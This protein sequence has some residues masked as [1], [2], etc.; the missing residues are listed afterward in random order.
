MSEPTPA[1]GEYLADPADLALKLGVP[2][3]DARLLLALR[4]AGDRFEGAIG[5]PVRLVTDDV[6][7]V[8]GDGTDTLLLRCRPIVGQP[9]VKVDGVAVTDFS[10]GRHSGILR[11]KNRACW[12]DDLDNVEVTYSHGW[13]QVP[14]DIQDAVLEQAE[15]QY[16]TVVAYQSRSAGSESVTY[17][18]LAAV[19]VTQRWT[20]AV[21]RY[22][23]RGDRS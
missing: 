17:S 8:S 21:N 2:A 15:T 3:D 10:V 7:H 6:E 4:R 12:P 18:A 20:D 9:A 19:G 5:Y 1:A 23:F 14:G 22:A 11:R 13:D 16:L